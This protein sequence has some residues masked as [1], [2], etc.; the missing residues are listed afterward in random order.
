MIDLPNVFGTADMSSPI[1]FIFLFIHIVSL[2]TAFGAVIAIDFAGLMWMIKKISLK[3]VTTIANT[4]Q[5][6]I[7]IGWVG[8]VFS[9]SFLILFKGYIDEL[10]VIKVFFV[11]MVGLNGIFLHFIK[12]STEALGDVNE[13]PPYIMYRMTLAST[14]SQLGWW[15]ALTIG[16]VHRHIWHEIRFP[17]NPWLYIVGITLIIAIAA[18]VIETVTRKTSTIPQ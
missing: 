16:F 7:W 15:G 17:A 10:T 5:K 8:L 6:L 18:L 3:N 2:I 11:L 4:T 1:F 12:K 9:G 13:L 14:I